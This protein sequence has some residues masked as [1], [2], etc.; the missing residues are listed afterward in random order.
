MT[1]LITVNKKHICNVAFIDVLS[2]IIISKV[3]IS[4]AIVS[5][6]DKSW[7]EVFAAKEPLWN[8]PVDKFIKLFG[9]IIYTGILGFFYKN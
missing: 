9:R 7:S 2:K 6:I 5:F 1:I 8:P 3:F 4:I